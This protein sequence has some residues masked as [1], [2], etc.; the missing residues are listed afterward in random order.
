MSQ[1]YNE[2]SRDRIG[3]FLFG[4]TGWQAAT[5][6]VSALPVF[7]AIRSQA[8]A[9]AALFTA[10][11]GLVTVVTVVPVRGRSSIGWLA[12]LTTFSIGG[13][14]GWTRHRAKAS[15]GAVD[16]LDQVDLPGALTGIEIHE[17][18]PTGLAGTR[19]AIIQNHAVRTWAVTAS[20]VHPGTGL[21]GVE[22][23]ARMG[24]GL[25]DLIDQAARTE[26]IEE[27][28]FLVRT[29]PEDGAERDQWIAAHRRP[30]SPAQVAAI[31]DQL[32]H[33]LT[34]A[35][36]RTEAF[37]TIVLPEARLAKA[38]K[39]AGRGIEARAH[40]L[41]AVISE[42]EAGL[43]GALGCTTVTWLTSPQLAAATRTGFAPGDRAGIIDALTANGHDP[44]VNAEVPWALAGPSGADPAAR[45]YSHDAWNSISSTLKLPT[46][47]AV[48]GALAPV[49]TP[50][51]AGERRS[52]LV[53]Y[54]IFSAHQ[55]ART[56]ASS[57]WSADMGAA[58]REK[59]R[60]KTSTKTRDE[61]SQVRALEAKLSRGHALT[62]PYAVATVTA[63]KTARISDY[64]RRLD[65][66]IR[67]AGYAPLRLDLA[68]DRGFA[69]SAI[70]LGI[71]L[72]RKG[73]S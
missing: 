14:A 1:V 32:Q 56:S 63:P 39:E 55:A 65:A 60:M 46:R 47:G 64:G 36:V 68:Q 35:S 21:R 15:Q 11:S 70:P 44:T 40:I 53:A 23:R 34:G 45:H 62:R 12:A 19:I 42:I 38:A 41:Y 9:S 29:V 24:R 10:V 61:T 43:K 49:L 69:A 25:A 71:S 22:D 37:V 6:A 59:A 66:S 27:I 50:T 5:V 16:D 31:N 20:I 33:A 8:W 4:W 67:A 48:L 7:W 73:D 51:G 13:L 2:Y 28:L 57:E 3:W 18:P 26:L 72:T 52:V 17:G 54:P 30:D 58:L